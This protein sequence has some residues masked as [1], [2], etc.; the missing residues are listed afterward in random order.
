MNLI[1]F[2]QDSQVKFGLML[3][4]HVVGA[5]Y[6][7]SV[8][9]HCGIVSLQRIE[10][11][12]ELFKVGLKVEIEVVFVDVGKIANCIRRATVLTFN[13]KV[14]NIMNGGGLAFVDLL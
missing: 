13:V 2:D 9:K 14:I 11:Y 6:R 7:E 10:K 8:H 4:G 5:C 12:S 3:W 1:F